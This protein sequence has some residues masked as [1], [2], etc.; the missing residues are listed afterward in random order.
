MFPRKVILVKKNPHK[1][2]AFDQVNLQI[3][4]NARVLLTYTRE[5]IEKNILRKLLT[6]FQS[7]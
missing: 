4:T 5:L 1:M 6:L 2:K 7:E 3:Y